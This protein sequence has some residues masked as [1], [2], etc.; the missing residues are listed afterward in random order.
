MALINIIHDLELGKIEVYTHSSS[1]KI[2]IRKSRKSGFS[3]KAVI[4]SKEYI[5]ELH[6]IIERE[7]D[8]LKKFCRENTKDSIDETFAIDSDLF[9]LETKFDNYNGRERIWRNNDGNYILFYTEK[10]DFND[11]FTQ[12][13]LEDLVVWALRQQ[14]NLILPKFVKQIANAIGVKVSNIRI[15][16]AQSRW[17]SCS[18]T[19]TISLSCFLIALPI[20]L[21]RYVIIHELSHTFEM[22]HSNKFHDI[23]DRLTG[24]KEKELEARIRKYETNIYTASNRRNHD[25]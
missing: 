3:L 12:M 14:A 7:R 15:T 5:G 19:G 17:G 23:V 1:R 20:D 8:K 13:A 9:K 4:P 25:K 22:N 21:I 18:S 11:Q 24:G 10:T 2:S 16:K 6:K